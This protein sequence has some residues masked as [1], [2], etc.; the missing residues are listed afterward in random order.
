M[1]SDNDSNAGDQEGIPSVRGDDAAFNSPSTRTGMPEQAEAPMPEIM[2]SSTCDP[3]D[4]A[5]RRLFEAHEP[6]HE[7]ASLACCGSSGSCT[8]PVL[9]EDLHSHAPAAGAEEPGADVPN[10]ELALEALLNHPPK[11][12]IWPVHQPHATG[13]DCTPMPQPAHNCEP[14]WEHSAV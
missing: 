8:G 12:S 13:L 5:R 2:A 14:E 3:V 7:P 1:P 9:L 11:S 6:F 4:N 10:A